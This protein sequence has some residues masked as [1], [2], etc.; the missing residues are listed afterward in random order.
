MDLLLVE[1]TS[2]RLVGKQLADSMNGGNED[3]LTALY[4]S[5]QHVYFQY[6][7]EAR[8]PSCLW[9]S[10]FLSSFLLQ[11]YAVRVAG[12]RCCRDCGLHAERFGQS[13]FD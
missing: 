9:G 11:I 4:T 5:Y 3:N 10:C 12:Q 1:L 7:M 13:G 6:N 8:L 2:D